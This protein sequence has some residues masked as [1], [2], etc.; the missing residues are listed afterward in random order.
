MNELIEEALKPLQRPLSM[1]DDNKMLV[2]V[3][4]YAELVERLKAQSDEIENA[5]RITKNYETALKEEQRRAAS[6]EK[7]IM[8]ASSEADRAISK[9][10]KFPT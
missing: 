5:W 3:E 8:E 2:D 9:L 4:L 6:L 10:N 7:L 1:T